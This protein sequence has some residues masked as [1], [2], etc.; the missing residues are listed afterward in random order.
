[1]NIQKNQNWKS[2]TDEN[3]GIEKYW[4]SI[5]PAFRNFL[6]FKIQTNFALL[7][8]SCAQ[9]IKDQ[10]LTWKHNYLKILNQLCKINWFIIKVSRDVML[11][12]RPKKNK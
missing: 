7:S 6:Q 10:S 9:E 4:I 11:G 12:Q 5:L 3:E 2:K 8:A 1:M